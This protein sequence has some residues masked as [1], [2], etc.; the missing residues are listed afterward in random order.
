MLQ[1]NKTKVE[2]DP[3]CQPHRNLSLQ[4]GMC[5]QLEF[6]EQDFDCA[7]YME[8][9]RLAYGSNGTCPTHGS[10]YPQFSRVSPHL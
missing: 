2:M 8:Q 9:I 6:T 4:C 5:L 10:V 3:F 7:S 1:Q